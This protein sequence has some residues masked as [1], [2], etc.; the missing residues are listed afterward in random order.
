MSL[1]P[2]CPLVANDPLRKRTTCCM[3]R[4]AQ[5]ERVTMRKDERARAEE[6]ARKQAKRLP[7][8]RKNRRR[9]V[10]QDTEPTQSDQTQ[11]QIGV[12]VPASRSD[13]LAWKMQRKRDV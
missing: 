1:C 7:G 8:N 9:L 11:L 13:S 3:V 6:Q 5:R 2:D 10:V 4:T 12:V